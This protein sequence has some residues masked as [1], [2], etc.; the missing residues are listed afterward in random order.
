MKKELGIGIAALG[1]AGILS[2]QIM[3]SA[4]KQDVDVGDAVVEVH[5]PTKN[6]ENYIENTLRSIV[7]QDLIN[8]GQ[9]DLILVDS[10]SEDRTQEIAAKYVDI[11]W[12]APDGKLSA[13]NFAM[14]KTDADIV[15]TADA[16]DI[17]P[18]GWL[19]N[20][21]APFSDPD[22]V[23]VHGPN[24][25]QDPIYKPILG[26]YNLVRPVGNFSASNSAV[27]T[28]VYRSLGGFDESIDQTD[29]HEM[30]HEEEV[31]FLK[32]LKKAGNV[33]YQSA[34]P[35]FTNMRHMPMTMHDNST[36]KRQRA[37]GERF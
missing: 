4:K 7:R 1:A 21:L 34:A 27:R 6:E 36:Y 22:T 30:F 24:M 29:R 17:Y 15:V 14:R 32:R 11:I 19:S 33:V 28:E 20:L 23:A 31:F 13:R 18:E 5:V 16:G 35:M 26:I 10:S 3:A 9:V 25:S 37:S 12:N 8:T 2:E